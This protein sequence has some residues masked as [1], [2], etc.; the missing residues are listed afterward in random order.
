MGDRDGPEA[1]VDA[2]GDE[3]EQQPSRQDAPSKIRDA[4][5]PTAASLVA[6]VGPASRLRLIMRP[7]KSPG[8]AG[9]FLA[10]R[11]SVAMEN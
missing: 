1:A 4:D 7:Q 3:Q 11:C 10:W 6:V 8:A 5:F 9:A 2:D